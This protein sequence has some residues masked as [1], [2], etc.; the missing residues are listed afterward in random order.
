M[1]PLSWAATCAVKNRK[2]KHHA[3]S[4]CCPICSFI[5]YIRLHPYPPR[6]SHSDVLCFV[7]SS[8]ALTCLKAWLLQFH[9]P[10]TRFLR[11]SYSWFPLLIQDSVKYHFLRGNRILRGALQFC[12]EYGKICCSTHRTT[13]QTK[14]KINSKKNKGKRIIIFY[15]WPNNTC[16]SIK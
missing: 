11:P 10:S 15:S 16:I 14:Q 7:Q 4:L 8:Q 3:R 13:E 9:L 1:S 5:S 12:A 2:I 6:S